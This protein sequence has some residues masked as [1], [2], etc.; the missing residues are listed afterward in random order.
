MNKLWKQIT[1]SDFSWEREALDF[2]KEELP[3]HEPYRAWA[4]FEFIA[5][6]GSINEVDLF[7]ITPKGAFLVEIKSHPGEISGDAAT[8]VWSNRG[9]RKAFDNPRI[10]AVRKSKKLASLLSSQRSARNKVTPFINTVVFLSAENVIN[11]LQGPAREHVCTRKNIFSELAKTDEYWS[12]KKLDRPTSKWVSRA[13]EEAGIKESL[14][15]RRVGFFELTELLDEADHFQDWLATHSETQIKRRIRIYLTHGKTVEEAETLQKAARLEFRL[16]EGIEHP[17]ILHAREY[18]QHEQGPALV[19]EH[20]ENAVRLDH[21]VSSNKIDT[22]DALSLIRQ[23]VEAVKFAHG[24]RLYH[25][26][27]SPQSIYISKKNDD[28]LLIKIGNWATAKHVSENDSRLQTALSHLSCLIQ[29]EAGPYLALEA[30]SIVDSDAV[31]LDI[32]SLGAIAYLLFT[33]QPPAENGLELQDKLSRGFGLQITDELNGAGQEL[34][35]LIQYSTHPDIGMRIGSADEF[36][37]YLYQVEDEITRP[38]NHRQ[39]NPTEAVPGDIFDGAITVKKRLGRGASS[40]AFVVDHKGQE[41]VLKLASEV[42]QN[43]RLL[44]EGNTLQKLRHPSIIEHYETLDFIGHTGLL[45]DYAN[46]GTLAQRLRKFGAIQLELLGRFGEDLLNAVC[47]LEEKGISHRDIKPEN[48]GLMQHSRLHLVLFDFSLSNVSAENFTAGTMAYMDPFIRDVGRRRWDDYAERF[49]VALTL[50]EMTTGILPTWANSDGLPPLIDGELDVDSV[51]FDPGLREVMAAFFRKALNRDVKQRFGN[52]EEMRLAWQQLFLQAPVH[53]VEETKCP[54]DEAETTTQIGLLPFSPQALDTLSRININTV[55]NLIKLPRNELVRMTGVG[56]K[57]RKELSDVVARLQERLGNQVISQPIV[58]SD[59]LMISVDQLFGIVIPKTNKGSDPS[60]VAFINEYLGRMDS[61]PPK[62]QH[63]VHWPTLVGLSAEIGVETV[64]A[65]EIQARLL[66]TWGKNKYITQ[67]RHDIAE[68]LND[69]GGLM[70]A[71][72]LSEAVLL[73][74]GSVHSSPQR[75]RNAQAVVRAAV[76]TELSRQQSRWVLRRSGKR[77]LVADNALERGEELADYAEAL[78]E[79]AEECGTQFPLLSPVRALERIR[80]V[81]APESFSSLSNH[82]LL[83]LAVA[84]SQGAALSSRAEFYPQGMSAE[85]SI[86]LGQ[87]ALLG[88]RSLSVEEVKARIQGRYPEAEPIPGRP[89]LDDLLQ[90]LD[91]GFQWD[92]QFRQGD[93]RGAYCL[94]QAGSTGGSTVRSTFFTTQGGEYDDPMAAREVEQFVK[95][96]TN[97][98]DSSRF[99]ALSVRPRQYLKAKVHIEKEFGLVVIGFDELLLRHLRQACASMQKPPKWEIILKADAADVS[100]RDWSL[101]QMLVKKVLPAMMAEIE[102]ESS[103]VLL[104]ESGLIGRYDLVN[105]WLRELRE[106]LV[107]VKSAKALILLTVSDVVANSAVIEGI[108]V[109]GGAG[110]KEFAPVQ[111]TWLKY[112]NAKLEKT[113]NKQVLTEPKTGSD[114]S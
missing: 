37:D 15:S 87:G 22:Q 41:R 102:Q 10:L 7:V 27:L 17:G 42:K 43:K 85:R 70:T 72:E 58:S 53:D 40:I 54:V 24:Q 23:L 73:R 25:R 59:N 89:K 78:G 11:K 90:R 6:D 101:L 44:S 100:S 14:R 111:S 47:H 51:V 50:Y 32:F 12:H 66:T 38:G 55:G 34:K 61:P 94:P 83:R 109:P 80:A 65:R 97:A 1:P 92:G 16:L 110:N 31:Y 5:Q 4:N 107:T 19:F 112:A 64:V 108:S 98:I 2:L 69:N 13:L 63:N 77:I 93:I 39:D 84:S 96:V 29:E 105:S 86:E 48:I 46:E 75:E 21:Y 9:K 20:N 8:W 88:T 45:I 57:T 36:L 76:E 60:R 33:G 114:D 30:H 79:L 49:S 91:L 68:L 74:R 99:L 113:E 81:P 104:T 28:S 26:T 95:I 103:A 35:D 71:I 62:G 3:D 67:L 106:H 18:Q 52:A 82:R 56:T